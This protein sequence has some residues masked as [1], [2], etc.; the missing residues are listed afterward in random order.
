AKVVIASARAAGYRVV[1]SLDDRPHTHGST[2]LGVPV[3][4]GI[5]ALPEGA[6]CVAA[7]GD[8]RVR[9][10]LAAQIR[11]VTWATVVHPQAFIAED[12]VV[13]PGT[14]VFAFAAIQPGAR[15][16]DHAIVNTAAVVEHDNSLADFA[17][18][19]TGARL[20]GG[21]VVGMGS[22]VGAG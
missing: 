7:I 22:F 5:E 9:E 20:T 21:V 16:G 2:V 10:K 4:G 6:A 3:V 17:Q 13:G 14:V 19:A 18:I 15:I 12:V 11:G 1:G 8:S